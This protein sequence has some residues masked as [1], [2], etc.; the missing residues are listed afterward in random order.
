MLNHL[1]QII[2]KIT[3]KVM[4]EE[5]HLPLKIFY[6]MFRFKLERRYLVKPVNPALVGAN[7]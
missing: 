7:I 1:T 6:I 5:V 3:V 4:V 2:S